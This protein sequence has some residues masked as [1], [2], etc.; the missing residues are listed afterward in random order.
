[1]WLKA[2][3]RRPISSEVVGSMRCASSPRALAS[4]RAAVA[5]GPAASPPPLAPALK[6]DRVHAALP[7]APARRVRPERSEFQRERSPR[8]ARGQTAPPPPPP[9][10]EL[11][12]DGVALP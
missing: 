5:R 6:P 9:P 3:A 8:R 10:L 7:P 1:M 12:D 2:M 4:T 11:A